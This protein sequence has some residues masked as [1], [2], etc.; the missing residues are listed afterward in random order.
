M[1]S[2]EDRINIK[3]ESCKRMRNFRFGEPVTNACAGEGNPLRHAFFVKLKVDNVQVTDKK[4]RFAN[5]GC[6][7]IYPG[8]LESDE[9]KR[10]FEPYWQAQFGG[11]SVNGETSRS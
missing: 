6:E 7:V 9:A 3:R 4:D 10:L 11:T 5:I 1:G 2:F 8:H